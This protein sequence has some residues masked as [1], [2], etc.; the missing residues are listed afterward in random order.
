MLLQ[1]WPSSHRWLGLREAQ[2]R[3]RHSDRGVLTF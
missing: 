1:T 2:D 3:E